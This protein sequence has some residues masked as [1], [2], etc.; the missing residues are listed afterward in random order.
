MRHSSSSREAELGKDGGFVPQQEAEYNIYMSN[1]RHK[2]FK[3]VQHTVSYKRRAGQ[4]GDKRE[5]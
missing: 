5:R 2:D 1:I 4:E 3:R